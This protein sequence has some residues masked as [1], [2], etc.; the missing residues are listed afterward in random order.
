[1]NLPDPNYTLQ[2]RWTV[3]ELQTIITY[4]SLTHNFIPL[5]VLIDSLPQPPAVATTPTP[6]AAQ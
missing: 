1:M 2:R 3:G 6:G 4:A 5:L